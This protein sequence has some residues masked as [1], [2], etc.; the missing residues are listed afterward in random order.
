MDFV[1]NSSSSSFILSFKDEYCIYNTLKEQFPK[2]IE[3]GWGAEKGYI[4]QLLE[5]IEEAVRL[6]KDDV[7]TL[8]DYE[9]DI[10]WD[11]RYK[12]C[13]EKCWSSK[14]AADYVESPEGQAEIA[15]IR[16]NAIEEITNKIGDNKVIVE[17][18]HGD[19]REGE[20]GVLE[21]YILP[22]LGCTV[23]QFPHH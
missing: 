20:D 8:F 14:E 19:G 22:K 16:Q 15:K 12:L 10:A 23:V 3:E 18:E 4:Y 13:S 5:E 6:T 2:D 21:N 1:T 9:K 7:I 17:V 11:L